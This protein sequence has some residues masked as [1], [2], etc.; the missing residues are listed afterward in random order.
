MHRVTKVFLSLFLPVACGGNNTTT[1]EISA[2][3]SSQPM[4]DAGTTPSPVRNNGGTV[5][6]MCAAAMIALGACGGDASMTDELTDAN[7]DTMDT[8][9]SN[10]GGDAGAP[11]TGAGAAGS[12]GGTMMAMNE[13]GSGGTLATGGQGGEGGEGAQGGSGAGGSSEPRFQPVACGDTLYSQDAMYGSVAMV[14]ERLEAVGDKFRRTGEYGVICPMAYWSPVIIPGEIISSF[15][16]YFQ[17]TSISGN[18]YAI[19]HATREEA[20]ELT[21][22]ADIPDGFIKD[23]YYAKYWPSAERTKAFDSRINS[24]GYPC[25]NQDKFVP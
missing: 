7:A 22:G 4:P 11:D 16:D 2:D 23:A 8:D 18:W 13:G 21:L 5:M 12:T 14:I 24:Q 3:A 25:H 6:S 20:D 17:A 19:K 15:S 9:A 10:E 1:R